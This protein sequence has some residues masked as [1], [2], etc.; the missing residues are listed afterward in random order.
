MPIGYDAHGRTLSVNDA[1][2][3]TIR[4][5]YD[6]YQTHGSIRQVADRAQVLGLRT[7]R[8]V[9]T[10][11][12]TTSGGLFDR[13]HIHH[14]L[15]N[16]LYAGRI[17]HKSQVYAGQHPAIIDPPVW[18]AVQIRLASEVANGRG[19]ANRA[20]RS[21]LAGKLFDESGDRLTPSHSRKNGK[22]L[23]YYISRRLVTDRRQRYP[24]AWRLPAEQIERLLGDLVRDT[25]SQADAVTR[26][27]RGLSAS[28]IVHSREALRR[29]DSRSDHLSL[30][31][32]VDLR[33]G[34]L[35]LRLLPQGIADLIGVGP[36]WI[37]T[38]GLTIEAPFQRR[39]RGVE[40]K[41]CLGAASPE[42][43]RTLVANIVKARRWLQMI[44][45]GKTFAEIAASEGTSKRRVQDIVDLALLA[46]DIMDAIAHGTQPVGLTSDRLIK[47][48]LPVLWADQRQRI[49]EW[50]KAVAA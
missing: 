24:D 4:T 50:S 25:L 7:R 8:R 43:D 27:T 45:D 49:A 34:A 9:R 30:I 5:L 23:R 20:T 35:T 47:C 39:R 44:L 14:I 2:A 40:L 16:P 18:E 17:R 22:R 28:E 12:H 19:T 11:G 15:T 32:R 3:A 41:L 38:E 36:D 48:G 6:L 33:P 13:G 37:N 26:V 21:P 46:P 29:S 1:E 10:R 42:I 31:D